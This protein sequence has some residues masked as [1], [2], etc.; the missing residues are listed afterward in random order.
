M[1]GNRSMLIFHYIDWVYKWSRNGRN[2]IMISKKSINMMMKRQP[3]CYIE[4]KLILNHRVWSVFYN[5]MINPIGIPF[6]CQISFELVSSTIEI[7]MIILVFFD[8]FSKIF[9]RKIGKCFTRFV[10]YL[11]L[12]FYFSSLQKQ[13]IHKNE[14]DRDMMIN[15]FTYSITVRYAS[16]CAQLIMK[17]YSGLFIIYLL[18]PV[19]SNTP[20]K[21][22]NS[23]MKFFSNVLIVIIFCIWI[24]CVTLS[25]KCK[26]VSK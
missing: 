22:E 19:Q 12:I 7:K 9:Q 20:E 8:L 5:K 14:N 4:R 21:K 24:C 15:F 11:L 6:V 25:L 1:E 2:W 17:I 18:F 16:C 13:S 10:D 23:T 3:N 26:S